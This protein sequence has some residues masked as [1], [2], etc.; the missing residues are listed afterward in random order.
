MDPKITGEGIKYTSAKS[1]YYLRAVPIGK[2][3]TVQQFMQ[4]KLYLKENA[5][6]RNSL[7]QHTVKKK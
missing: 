4:K 7:N 1:K 6:M 3:K 2:R 5:T